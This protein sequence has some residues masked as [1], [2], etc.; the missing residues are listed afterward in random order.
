MSLRASTWLRWGSPD[1]YPGLNIV[2]NKD[3]ANERM[4]YVFK[5]LKG[6]G[7][8]V[9][10]YR[11]V[12]YAKWIESELRRQGFWWQANKIKIMIKELSDPIRDR[13]ASAEAT[14]TKQNAEVRV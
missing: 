11:R 7:F 12:H 8:N 1:N 6:G 2:P 13:L 9:K 14:I 4:A 5:V 10:F 3:H